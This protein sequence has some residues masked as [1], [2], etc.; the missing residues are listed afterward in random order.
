MSEKIQPRELED[1]LPSDLV[2]RAELSGE[3]IERREEILMRRISLEDKIVDEGHV[4]GLADSMQG[5]R[6][7]L[8]EILVRVRRGG[9]NED[10]VDYDIIDGFHRVEAANSLKWETIQAKVLYGCSDEEMY[11]LRILAANSVR[12]VKFA[13]L[14]FWMRGAWN[15]TPWR[16]K[17][18][19]TQ[20]CVMAKED[21]SGKHLRLSSKEV[22]EIKDW[23]RNKANLWLIPPGS[24]YE[25]LSTAEF[26]APALIRQVRVKG[27]KQKEASLTPQKLR[28]IV[29]AFPQEP[30]LQERLG[31]F[32]VEK[33]VPTARL[34]I[35]VKK[36]GDLEDRSK[37]SEIYKVFQ[38]VDREDSEKED[39]EKEVTL[40][41]VKGSLMALRVNLLKY[42]GLDKQD[43][44]L[45]FHYLE[46][47]RQILD[48]NK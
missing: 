42:Q 35:I 10:D 19:L 9:I 47:I 6:K 23:V 11:D 31:T 4:A 13:R 15:Q 26:V 34:Q 5:P 7:Q 38:E 45:I 36:V 22:E 2:K 44:A 3:L 46:L 17:I 33:A 16:E 8:S 20:A 28:F 32:V 43:S 25:N 21:T 18:S 39:Q 1:F 29:E 48:K 14:I 27:G 41:Q 37:E 30:E 12:S 40:M 24:L